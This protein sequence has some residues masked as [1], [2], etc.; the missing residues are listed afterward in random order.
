MLGLYACA[1]LREHGFETVYCSGTR[2]QRSKFIDRFGAI[3]LY[4]GKYF[5][6]FSSYDFN[7]LEQGINNCMFYINFPFCFFSFF[8][9]AR[10]STIRIFSKK[11]K[12]LLLDS[13]LCFCFAF[14]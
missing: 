4:D 12:D 10:R 8:Y 5:F 3:P 6:N 13:L 7:T 9:L 1:A 14:I 11:Y 2:L